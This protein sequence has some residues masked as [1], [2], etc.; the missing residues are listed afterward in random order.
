MTDTTG[1]AVTSFYPSGFTRED[2]R[3]M[4][5]RV[6][7][8]LKST[9]TSVGT[10][11]TVVDSSMVRYANSYFNGAT[12]H[13]LVGG[14]DYAHD[15]FVTD[16][17]ATTGTFTISPAMI[18]GGWN[19]ADYEIYMRVT[20]VDINDALNKSC[21]GV[22]A[23][24]SLTPS[25]TTLDYSLTEITGLHSPN[26]LLGVWARSLSRTNLLPLRLTGYQVE[27]D[28]GLMTLRLPGLMVSTDSLWITY[29]MGED[30]LQHDDDKV[31]L[32]AALVRARSVVYLIQNKLSMQDDVG[33]SRWGT[34]L[35][36]WTEQ[37]TFEERKLQRHGKKVQGHVWDREEE[38]RGDLM[39]N[40]QDLYA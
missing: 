34:L 23:K 5:A 31:N 22:A 40:L 29:V 2:L 1:T 12:I 3:V 6:F 20:P 39:L 35:R 36:H 8:Y 19:G 30:A 4:V 26:Q 10:E 15:G 24:H 33:L 25:T 18:R 37:L 9:T 13:M 11:A 17:V 14:T 16:F 32:P 21:Y 38:D 27:D 28:Q 7:G